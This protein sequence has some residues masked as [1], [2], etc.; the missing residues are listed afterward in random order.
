MLNASYSV[1]NTLKKA[2]DRFLKDKNIPD[3]LVTSIN[4]K[5][6]ILETVN[7]QSILKHMLKIATNN[8]KIKSY[9]LER[10]IA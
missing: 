2:F 10:N 9:F 3:A 8:I 1:E 4:M 7:C 6:S 5:C